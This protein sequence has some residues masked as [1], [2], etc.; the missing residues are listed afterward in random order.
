MTTVQK[1]MKNWT[2]EDIEFMKAALQLAEKGLGYTA[3]NP[4]VGAVVVKDG[5]IVG[6]GYHQKAGTPHAEV[7]ALRDAGSLAA[8]GKIYVTLEPCNHHG[9]TPPCTQAILEAGI[10]EV[11]IGTSDPN[12][13]VEGG[14]AA[15]L[16][17][18]GL[19]VKTGCL[20]QEARLL[21]APFVKHLAKGIPWVRSK[22][23]MSLDGKIATRTGHSKWI[24]N[25]QARRFGHRLREI[26]DAILVGKNTV[27]A[28]N[29]SLTCRHPE[30]P[31]RD[32]ARII[33]DSNM[34]IPHDM[35]V[36]AQESSAPTIIAALESA[37]TRQKAE[38]LQETGV[39][40]WLL[41]PDES[42]KVDLHALLKQMG[43]LGMQS[44]LVEGGSMV[45]GSFWDKG[46]V[47]EAFFFYAPIVIGGTE[48][49][50]C[51][52][53]KGA[54]KVDKAPRLINFD[55]IEL[56]DNFLVHGVVS[57]LQALWAGGN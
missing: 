44:L 31:G 57:D 23:A 35:K 19:D 5:E 39:E 32:P 25:E 33:L 10:K 53:G 24:T 15:F 27:L 48:S 22:A 38:Q 3:P 40:V 49:K 45:H 11:I 43:G 29:P 26:S 55:K 9:R 16:A 6:K 14:G 34:T 46:L 20:E 21:I 41:P 37:E 52:G 13:K 8:G 50:I 42:G 30:G 12:P 28:D 4:A 17:N 7:H 2:R 1:N 36:F 51:I 47:D 54:Q 56:G 18:Q